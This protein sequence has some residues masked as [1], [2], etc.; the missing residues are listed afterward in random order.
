MV[1]AIIAAKISAGHHPDLPHDPEATL[2]YARLADL[3]RTAYHVHVACVIEHTQ[4]IL[5]KG[6]GGH[7][8]RRRAEEHGQNHDF[9]RCA[10]STR[11]GG[12]K[13]LM[14]TGQLSSVHVHELLLQAAN[15][16]TGAGLMQHMTANNFCSPGFVGTPSGEGEVG[17]MGLP[18]GSSSDAPQDKGK[19]KG[20]GKTKSKNPN[21]PNPPAHFPKRKKV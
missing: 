3:A 5:I 15:V 17:C 21:D 12:L 1:E 2:Y 4:L 14:Q 10:N 7:E 20:K 9:C 8:P 13:L 6:H 11:V 19:G 18:G 16:L